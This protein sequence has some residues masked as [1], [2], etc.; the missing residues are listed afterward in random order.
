MWYII[1]LRTM[2]PVVPETGGDIVVVASWRD[3]RCSWILGWREVFLLAKSTHTH[4][5]CGQESKIHSISQCYIHALVSLSKFLFVPWKYFSTRHAYQTCFFQLTKLQSKCCS[6][7]LMI[8]WRFASFAFSFS[9]F[10]PQRSGVVSKFPKTCVNMPRLYCSCR[11]S[12]G[13]FH[14]KIN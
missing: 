10:L 6:N 11:W 8:S 5:H 9:A 14:I 4:T 2:E 12:M 13:M 1:V 3:F 7:L